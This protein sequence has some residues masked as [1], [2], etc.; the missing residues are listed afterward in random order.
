MCVCRRRSCRMSEGADGCCFTRPRGEDS[1][2][3]SGRRGAER[4]PKRPLAFIFFSAPSS[5]RL[6]SWAASLLL[7]RF[8]NLFIYF[9]YLLLL[10]RVLT[11]VGTRL[12]AILPPSGLLSH[13]FVF[14]FFF[15]TPVQVKKRLS[16]HL[17]SLFSYFKMFFSSPSTSPS[18]LSPSIN[19][20]LLPAY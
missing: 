3:G 13:L 11:A 1:G 2:H 20:F 12:V 15:D 17:N 5:Q 7:L 19:V 9:F 4:E 6:F 14:I 8:F 16:S 10:L 18:F